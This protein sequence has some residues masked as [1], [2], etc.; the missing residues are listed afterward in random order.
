MRII[1]HA[2]AILSSRRE[3]DVCPLSAGKCGALGQGWRADDTDVFST[4]FQVSVSAD[5]SLA[6]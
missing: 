4:K 6:C 1:P 5:V 2:N 3:A